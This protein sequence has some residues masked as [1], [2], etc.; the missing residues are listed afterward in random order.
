MDT[1]V[2]IKI[3]FGLLIKRSV[4][5]KKVARFVFAVLLT[6]LIVNTSIAQ[7]NQPPKPAV[8]CHYQLGIGLEQGNK[9]TAINILGVVLH[10]KWSF[11]C[12]LTIANIAAG[13]YRNEAEFVKST[14]MSF[15]NAFPTNVTDSLPIINIALVNNIIQIPVVIAYN[16]SLKNNY[17]LILG[18]GT[19]IDINADQRANFEQHPKNSSI[20]YKQE[21]VDLTVVALNNCTVS[22][23]IQ[24]TWSNLSLQLIPFFSPQLKKV[25][26]KPESYYSG[27]KLR[28]FYNF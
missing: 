2:S 11:T 5:N 19:D 25:I 17:T 18:L 28:A 12:G 7:D 24:K 22:T 14:A 26:Y 16:H 6:F 15:R 4:F 21:E 20:L 27:F 8:K 10:N 13:R 1:F 9:L 23:G 3:N